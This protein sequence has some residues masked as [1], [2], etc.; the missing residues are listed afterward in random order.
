M[1][2]IAWAKVS[3]RMMRRHVAGLEMHLRDAAV[4][5]GEET[6]QDLGEEAALLAR[7]AGP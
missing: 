3:T 7:R 4:V 1:A 5:A 6:E 2:R